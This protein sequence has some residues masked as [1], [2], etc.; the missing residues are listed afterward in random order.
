MLKGIFKNEGF[1]FIIKFLCLFGLLYF[2][3]LFFISITTK[4]SNGFTIF[5][6]DYLNFID[7]IRYSVLSVSKLL[8]KLMGI[9][10]FIQ[11]R[12]LLRSF[13]TDKAL[14]MGYDCIGYGV[15]SFWTAF[16]VANNQPWKPKLCWTVIGCLLTWVINC[17]RVTTLMIALSNNWP[18]SGFIDH[19]TLFNIISYCF[20]L[21]MIYV[22]IRTNKTKD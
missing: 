14:H 3:C 18:I 5:L 20:L 9:E 15:M 2:F 6:R 11:D 16:V 10:C 12:I 13:K 7:W 21:A 22:Y 8:C 1:L 4:G 17:V 19:H